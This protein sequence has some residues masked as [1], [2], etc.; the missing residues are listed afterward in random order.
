MLYNP[1]RN[2]DKGMDD[3]YMGIEPQSESRQYREGY[4]R[5]QQLLYEEDQRQQEQIQPPQI[6]NEYGNN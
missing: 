6:Q 4:E 3:A 1:Y 5:C 2:Y